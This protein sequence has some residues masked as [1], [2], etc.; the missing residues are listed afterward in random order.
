MINR[1]LAI[2]NWVTKIR[3]DSNVYR[4]QLFHGQIPSRM[5]TLPLPLVIDQFDSIC[6]YDTEKQDY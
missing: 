6:Q 1:R 5:L 2:L 4:C 3:S